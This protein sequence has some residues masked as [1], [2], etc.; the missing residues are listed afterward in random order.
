[1]TE[2]RIRTSREVV[3][4]VQ[5]A[6]Q[7]RI[8]RIA[9]F[10]L[11]AV[12]AS[13]TVIASPPARA[14]ASSVIADITGIEGAEDIAV[15]SRGQVY[16]AA[17]NQ[18]QVVGIDP[19]RNTIAAR[20]NVG[21]VP[22][23]IAFSPDGRRAIV[24]NISS[25]TLSVIEATT[26]TVER[27]IAVPQAPEGVAFGRDGQRA[28]AVHSGVASITA[29]DPSS[30]AA[31][32]AIPLPQDWAEY[33]AISPATD[34]AVVMMEE[35]TSDLAVV[36]LAGAGS[37]TRTVPLGAIGVGLAL[38]PDGQRAY[39]LVNDYSRNSSV[40]AVDVN[41]GSVLSRTG[42]GLATRGLAL[43]QDGTTLLIAHQGSAQAA[44]AATGFATAPMISVLDAGN[45]S[46]RGVLTIAQRRWQRTQAQGLGV[47]PDGGRAWLSAWGRARKGVLVLDATA[48]TQVPGLP[49]GL[50]ARGSS[51]AVSVRWS[52]PTGTPSTTLVNAV[53]NAEGDAYP[54]LTCVTR[55]QEC[56][57]RGL[58][59]GISYQLTVQARNSSGWG[60]VASS[61]LAKRR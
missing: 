48:L 35:Q 25:D 55:G 53:P 6:V 4:P 37:L 45:L 61:T 51:R 57:I 50:S 59:P 27:T 39:A 5:P 19:L 24:S 52:A 58:I 8:T 28:Y 22:R 60:P 16:V 11:S 12:L 13:A 41:S 1:M 46:T 42:I 3:V 30:G 40:I 15:S 43:T 20:I 14:D 56:L 49:T 33:I 31:L 32:R 7:A 23:G 9:G 26:N 38:S 2:A 21:Q 10:T 36:S 47:S 34:T 17:A 44:S 18:G 54:I 29:V